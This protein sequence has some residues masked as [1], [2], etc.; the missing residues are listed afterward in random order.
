M[1]KNGFL[2][3][4]NDEFYSFL[5]KLILNPDIRT[6]LGEQGKKDMQIFDYS[7]WKDSYFSALGLKK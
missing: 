5:R 2:A 6:K 3:Q 7:H 4:T 1:K